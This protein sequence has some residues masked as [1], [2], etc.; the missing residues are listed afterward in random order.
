MSMDKK[1][2]ELDALDEKIKRAKGE[3]KDTVIAL[4]KAE[5]DGE[6]KAGIQAGIELVG[7]IAVSTALGVAL[8]RWLDTNPA[9]TLVLFFLGVVVGFFNVYRVSQNLGSAVG[10]S[11]LHKHEKQ[12]KTAPEEDKKS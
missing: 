8:D 9:F 2:S 6:S 5:E 11:Q 10:Y 7:A 12:A 3:D 1:Q 4:E